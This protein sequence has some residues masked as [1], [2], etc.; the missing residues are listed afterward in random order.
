MVLN[1][2]ETDVDCGGPTCPACAATK[3]CKLAG[4]CA[5]GVCTAGVCAAPACTDAV[6]NGDETDVDCGGATCPKCAATQKCKLA[7]DCA[8]GVCTAGAC[9]Q[10]SCT[11]TVQNGAETDVD[12]GGG[13]CPKCAEKKA[14]KVASDCVTGVCSGGVCHPKPGTIAKGKTIYFEDLVAAARITAISGAKLT[15]ES[16]AAAGK[17]APGQEVLL[18]NMQ[19]TATDAASVGNHE[20]LEVDSVS[21]ADVLLVK[22]PAKGYGDNKGNASLKTQK[23]FL[24]QVLRYSTLTVGGTL[25]ARPWNGTAKG[26][27]L[28][29]VRATLSL[30]VAAG[31]A[32]TTTAAG[33]RSANFSC[34]GVSGVPG[35]SLA[36]MPSTVKG[37]CY[38]N[39]PTNTA[40]F[41]GG[42]GGLS[43]CNTYSCATQQ[44]GA[45]G[46][47]AGHG[48]VG[49]AGQA[50]GAK[51]K[52]GA[53][54]LLY[55]KTDLSQ[56]FLGSGG[57]AGA[58]GYSGPGGG[59]YGGLGGG[60][61]Y[62]MAPTL[63]VKGAVTANGKKGGENSNCSSSHGS[64][65]GGGGAGGSV[66]LSGKT[67]TITAGT[68]TALGAK[69]GCKGGGSGGSGRIRVDYSS[70]NGVAYPGGAG[71]VTSPVAY[72]AKY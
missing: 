57:G 29:A 10:P 63:T 19:G 37:Q 25:A 69:G 32:V 17:F 60:L 15:A 47:G 9:Q 27:G 65:S 4:D 70:L 72:M 48:T 30:E 46:G 33:Y 54:G 26:L 13:A 6:L 44:L 71:A 42:G 1:G 28:V 68:V 31:G 53:A 34:N 8:S 66:R 39:N 62:L 40:N 11:D 61:I 7:G 24:V 59:T 38:Y 21:G 55:G 18:I 36:P 16:A 50:N 51:H 20:L 49:T 3:K 58:G 35:E 67:V 45:G 43:S 12:C 14:C 56:I 41:G 64:G 22:A 52:G 23:V 5:S 2:D